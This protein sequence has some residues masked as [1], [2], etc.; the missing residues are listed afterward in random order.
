MKLKT[1]KKQNS[2]QGFDEIL[3]PSAPTSAKTAWALIGAAFVFSVLARLYWVF[4]A[5]EYPEFFWNGELM[6]NTNDGYVFAE[7]ARDMLAGF[8]QPNDLSFYG[9]S[10]STLTYWIVKILGVKIETAMLYLS[11]AASSLIVAPVMLIALEYRATAAGFVAALLASVAN[12]YYNRTMAGYYDTDMLTIVLPVF[13]LWGLIRVCER[14]RLKFSAPEGERS[15]Q[16]GARSAKISLIIAPVSTLVYFWW[17]PSSSF[18]LSAAITGLFLVYTL[19]FGRKNALFYAQLAMLL[20]AISGALIWLKILLIGGFYAAILTRDSVLKFKPVL[21]ALVASFGIFAFYGG[22]NPIIFQVKFYLLRATPDSISAGFHYFNV[23]QTIQESGIVDFTLFCERISGHVLIFA[24][25]LAGVIFLCFKRRSFALN[26]AMLALGFLALKGG[27]RFTIYAVPAMALGFGYAALSAVNF[28][29]LKGAASYAIYALVV[30]LAL[31]APLKHIYDYKATPVFTQNEV[32]IL[33]RLKS[34]A[35]REDYALA[36]WDYGYGIR[37]YSDVKT[38]IDGGKHLGADN[39]AVSFALGENQTRSANMARLDV[40]YT[41]RN[42]NEKFGEILPKILADTGAGDIDEFL[43]SLGSKDFAPLRKTR[44]IYYY[45]PY[46]M[47]N[48]FPPVLQFSRLNLKDGAELK[49]G[50]FYA[51]NKISNSG[52]RIVAGSG[53]SVSGDL[54]NLF[55][56]GSKFALNTFYD[57]SGEPGALKIDEYKNDANSQFYAI[58]LRQ[59]GKMVILDEDAINSAFVQLFML[60]RFDSELFEPVIL[61]NEAKIYRLKR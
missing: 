42:F 51:S 13:A 23:N 44:E 5:G 28:L 9:S 33:D 32:A 10:L 19:V 55:Y 24:I 25:S 31:A 7:G 52:G 40:E 38:L 46:R 21:A 57:V 18:S 50:L 47:I 36:W 3:A 61:E 20:I 27:L 1:A 60:E 35:G 17:Y 2:A 4:W 53:F 14:G 22:L 48:I 6:I 58:L 12:S 16:S 37:Y 43:A 8:H 30:V 15:D 59:Y 11:V 29:K 41:E 26:L 39:Y 54:K 56:G 49:G 34:I 45:L